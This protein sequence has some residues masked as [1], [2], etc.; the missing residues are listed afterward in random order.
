MCSNTNLQIVYILWFTNTS[1]SPTRSMFHRIRQNG[2]I[3]D[4]KYILSAL[5]ITTGVT[6][7]AQ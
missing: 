1:Y 6:K 5:F 4:C 3:R 7:V 2:G